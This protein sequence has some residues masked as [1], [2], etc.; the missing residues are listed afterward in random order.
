M[1]HVY[2][3]I[4][5]PSLGAGMAR[6]HGGRA[7]SVLA[8]GDVA[9][10]VSPAGP[11]TVEPTPDNV[12]HHERL[13]GTLMARHAVL[14]MR[15]ATTC[16]GDA[17]ARQLQARRQALRDGLRRVAGRV[18]IAV[19]ISAALQRTTAEP[20]ADTATPGRTYLST[21]MAHRRRAA[22]RAARLAPAVRRLRDRIGRL[23]VDN[24]WQ[25]VAD[26][27]PATKGSCLIARHR[28]AGF[29]D[30]VD[31]LAA[32]C[33]DLAVTCTGPWAP[34]SFVGDLMV[35]EGGTDGRA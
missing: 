32:V 22:D 15:F 29:V 6:G 30:A 27:A 4:D 28:V 20:V 23:A 11:A 24:V 33:P 35:P 31:G 12:W 8:A 34:Y 7:V 25:E 3:I 2:G 18:E 21:R 5:G 17:L 19:R 1:L 16:D 10:V 9:A 26:G 14:P 13:L